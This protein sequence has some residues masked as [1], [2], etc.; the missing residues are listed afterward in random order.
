M[1]NKN[2][3][4]NPINLQEGIKQ[5]N[6]NNT[7]IIKRSANIDNNI[8]EY[9]NSVV[10]GYRQPINIDINIE[11]DNVH[12]KTLKNCSQ[13]G[14]MND[15]FIDLNNQNQN[16]LNYNYLHR[17]ANPQKKLIIQKIINKQNQRQIIMPKNPQHFPYLTKL[18]G[19]N[20]FHMSHE[21][22]NISSDSI[23]NNS[24]T[25]ENRKF[26]KISSQNIKENFSNKNSF[27]NG[28][29]YS[30]SKSNEVKSNYQY[31]I[32]DHK[33]NIENGKIVMN[34]NIK[35][36]Y[37][38]SNSSEMDINGIREELRLIHDNRKYNYDK[39]VQKINPTK[40]PVAQSKKIVE[41][42]LGLNSKKIEHNKNKEEGNKSIYDIKS[43]PLQKPNIP[44]NIDNNTDINQN[45]MINNYNQNNV[46]NKA[47]N[48]NINMNPNLNSN[49]NMENNDYNIVLRG[50]QKIKHINNDLNSYFFDQQNINNNQ[51][52]TNSQQ[53]N[54]S[55]EQDENFINRNE[56]NKTKN[57]ALQAKPNI[58]PPI[59]QNLKTN[60][61]INKQYNN[62]LPPSMSQKITTQKDVVIPLK[63]QISNPLPQK[64]ITID[65]KDK[66]QK[67]YNLQKKQNISNSNNII[68]IPKKSLSQ[69]SSSPYII[70]S[71]KNQEIK[72]INNNL[73]QNSV[74]ELIKHNINM[75]H[76]QQNPYIIG[77][78]SPNNQQNGNKDSFMNVVVKKISPNI[79]I[80]INQNRSNN[81]I[82]QQPI[83]NIP[84]NNINLA[85][86]PSLLD[87]M[88]QNPNISPQQQ[89]INFHQEQNQ[90]QS[91][92][93][94]YHQNILE[95]S[96][97]MILNHNINL[98]QNNYMNIYR[99]P[100]IKVIKNKN[101][102]S[103][104]S[105]INQIQNENIQLNFQQNQ[106]NPQNI[107][108]IQNSNGIQINANNIN[109]LQPNFQ[110]QNYST[111]IYQNTPNMKN[112]QMINVQKPNNVNQ[113]NNALTKEQIFQMQQVPDNTIIGN[114]IIKNGKAY[115][116]NQFNNNQNLNINMNINQN[117]LNNYIQPETPYIQQNYN[118][119]NL[120]N[121]NIVSTGNVN[122]INN[123]Q[124]INNQ[125]QLK[126]NQINNPE[127]NENEKNPQIQ[128]QQN[129]PQ[130]QNNNKKNNTEQQIK[131]E[132][133]I[134]KNKKE[135]AS[136]TKDSNDHRPA[137]QY[138]V[139]RCRPVFAVPPSKKRALSQGRPFNFIHKYYD[140]NYILEDDDEESVKPEEVNN[141]KVVKNNNS[142]EDINNKK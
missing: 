71:Q 131:N 37:L 139:E 81:I 99:N 85:Q 35:D 75:I 14:S 53:I 6:F 94:I 117:P 142:G 80:N 83:M 140:E 104:T 72:S 98:P 16:I 30:K 27:E 24:Q 51:L 2:V 107:I 61:N 86:Q 18:S 25:E 132:D 109:N 39:R 116:L 52:S 102:I 41:R 82:Q 23:S 54:I 112:Q 88:S 74:N 56:K 76:P 49:N 55:K 97:K 127:L 43:H 66:S 17:K 137:L 48:T 15:G 10:Y 124:L 110:I 46:N 134:N 118:N 133:N 5:Q 87:Y 122:D 126:D 95:Q 106:L 33:T 57:I 38:K 69:R 78:N 77:N 89:N 101:S 44:Y 128:N 34:N 113:I 73:Q 13:N 92:I 115:Y 65:T 42:I 11:I 68:K 79:N 70:S 26:I 141:I 120:I 96:S 123:R 40:I 28:Q 31:I 108:N 21:N 100:N 60:L 58:I 47:V 12:K 129:P 84:N 19:D 103:D 63:H 45:I 67:N 8:N 50:K 62:Q 93:N 114:I 1:E 4:V 119:Q 32:K 9:P 125:N 91:K 111:N 135:K 7:V 130:E 36:N 29:N 136:R 121:N 64:V 59:D 3:I 138:K 22:T 105:N 20:V 90:Q